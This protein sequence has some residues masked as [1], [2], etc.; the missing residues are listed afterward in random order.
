V[1]FSVMAGRTS[2]PG[3]FAANELRL[4]L[5]WRGWDV[6]PGQQRAN[7][8]SS[9]ALEWVPWSLS[10]GV[11]HQTHMARDDGSQPALS[12]TALRL[13]RALDSHWH[14]TGQAAI[15]IT[16]KAGGYASGQ[17]GLA[18]LTSEALAS[19]WRFGAAASLGAAGGG[20]VRVGGGWIGEAQLL[21]RLAVSPSWSVQADAGWLRGWDS[22][23]NSPQ[24]ALSAVYSYARLKGR[25]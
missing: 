17:L 21:A 13:E 14:L 12:L 8:A 19:P 2:S 4:E 16:G 1:A 15:A 6:V 20:S 10:S 3:P 23:L 25:R 7:G 5:G 24:L 11:I 18:W 9:S 22:R